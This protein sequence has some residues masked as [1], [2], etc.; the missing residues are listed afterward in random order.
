MN[1][2]NLLAYNFNAWTDSLN[3]ALSKKGT[4]AIAD[5]NAYDTT[6]RNGTLTLTIGQLSGGIVGDLKMH[7]IITEGHLYYTA[8]NGERWFENTLRK[9]VTP[10]EGVSVSL[11][12]GQSLNFIENYNLPVGINAK[13]SQIIVFLQSTST[14]KVY[15]VDEKSLT[16]N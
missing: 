5:S 14:A 10:A 11:S 16:G 6:S 15:A 7:I 9:L 3:L 12:S 13:Y 1:G 4:F 2:S 8:P